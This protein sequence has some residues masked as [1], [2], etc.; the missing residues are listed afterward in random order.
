MTLLKTYFILLFFSV[1]NSYVLAQDIDMFRTIYFP[2]E[3]YGGA[4]E[5]KS[6]VKQE[7]VY[8]KSLL[9]EGI[10]GSVFITYL[11]DSEGKVSY[12]EVIDYGNIDF[13]NE[14]ERVFNKILWKADQHRANKDLGY[15]KIKFNFNPKRYTKLV[16]KR[17]YDSLP[18]NPLAVDSSAAYYTINQL[19]VDPKITN[20]ESIDKFIN[21][22]FKYPNIALQMGISGRVTIEFIIEPY[23]LI[24]NL[25]II[26]AVGGGCNDE[27]IRLIRAIS[28]EPGIKNGIAVRTLYKYQLNF[29]HPGGTI[30]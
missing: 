22:N 13:R 30:R 6:F 15:E 16:K 7:I 5:L 17:G 23:G 11:I 3:P 10:K 9:K 14:A 19:D 28:W 1:T 8:P 24:S 25:R 18:F 20:A 27:T 2:A 26:E 12:K 29:V 4:E 21:A